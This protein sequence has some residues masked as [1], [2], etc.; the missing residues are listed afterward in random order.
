[1][2]VVRHRL[3]QITEEMAITLRNVS[4]SPTV[5]EASDFNV[6]IMT[7]DS[8][9]VTMGSYVTIH[10]TVLP[11][12]IQHIASVY[13]DDVSE[14][15]MF[16]ANDPYKGALHQ[17]D[18][19][20]VAPFFYE[21][22]LSAWTG[23]VAHEV[24]I[25][26]MQPGAP[27]GASE[28]YQEGLRI[29]SLKIVNKGVLKKDVLDMILS[30][31]RQPGLVGLDIKAR[32]ATNNTAR[33]RLES[34]FRRYS[35]ETA[36]SMMNQLIQI[37]ETRLRQRLRELP[38]GNFPQNDYIDHDGNTSHIY[39]VKLQLTKKN[40][41]LTFDFTGSDGQ[42]K[43]PINCTISGTWA[44]VMGAVLPFLCYDIP[45]N[46]GVLHPISVIA[47][48]GSVVNS[49]PPAP[50]GLASTAA[51]FAVRNAATLAISR[52]LGSSDKY[53]QR[54]GAVWE[55]G[56][57]TPLTS[58]EDQYGQRFS[59]PFQSSGGAGGMAYKDGFD[60]SFSMSPTKPSMPNVEAAEAFAP[61][62][63]L[64]HRLAMDSGGAGKFRGG[65]ACEYAFI[66]H[67][68]SSVQVSGGGHGSEV[69]AS[70]GI[71]GGYPGGCMLRAIRRKTNIRSM[72]K[73]GRIPASLEELDGEGEDFPSKISPK[74][75][76]DDSV[77]YCRHN[78]GGGYGDPLEREVDSVLHDALNGFV[79]PRAASAI[80]GVSVDLVGKEVDKQKTSVL[81][82]EISEERRRKATD[83][84]TPTFLI[85]GRN[86]GSARL[87]ESL[88]PS[89]NGK[90]SVEC[91]GCGN[92]VWSLG[93]KNLA[94]KFLEAELSEGG[95]MYP[96]RSRALLR[97]FLCPSC[98]RLLDSELILRQ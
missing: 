38:D 28:T 47:P 22:R 87:G 24:D 45:W 34:L 59:F 52:M 79:S 81:R 65:L 86:D 71:Y 78:A 2:E 21:G 61:I 41:S 70:Q 56:K 20:V 46:H 8:K 26:A 5:K 6:G 75:F 7:P 88:R 13:G 36:N 14:G 31:V 72:L 53:W 43:G 40:D 32:I 18:V 19:A 92:G 37:S 48:E 83:T 73:A 91:A 97:Q 44:G 35:S 39:T 42:A 85:S 12:I 94:I 57:A 3:W 29:P 90:S 15:D 93:G 95:L 89:K 58:G 1:M 64:Y 77:F 4:G 63:F 82:A 84:D 54:A 49:I 25:G 98:G 68:S 60:S 69:P 74:E 50:V 96:K 67:K 11:T 62:L 23:V 9:M 33:N 17:L 10:A 27:S 80:Y 30:N 55:G 76:A 66:R 16:I 51:S